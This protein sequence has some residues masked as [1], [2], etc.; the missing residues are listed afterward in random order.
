MY[1]EER[2]LSVDLSASQVRDVLAHAEWRT[3]DARYGPVIE[4]KLLERWLRLCRTDLTDDVC[5]GRPGLTF[6]QWLEYANR[7]I[8]G[9]RISLNRFALIDA[10]S[11]G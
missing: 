8:Y 9:A 1:A 7:D 2:G 11:D 6:A 3:A 4:V 5:T 10:F